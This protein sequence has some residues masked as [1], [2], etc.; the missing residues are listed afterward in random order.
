MEMNSNIAKE[1]FNL[2]PFNNRFLAR[3]FSAGKND[4]WIYLIGIVATFLGYS[5][6]QLLTFKPLVDFALQNGVTI[7]QSN[8]NSI[9]NADEIGMNRSVMLCILGGMFVFALLFLL[10]VVKYLH[11]KPIISII[12]AFEK[13]R[14]NRYFF[15]FLIW[16]ILNGLYILTMYL[17]NPS[18][19]E[20]RF[21][22]NSFLILL[23][24][25]IVFL[26]I[27][28]AAEE[29]FL[30]SYLMQGL[31]IVF[32]NGIM[33]L[34]ITSV[35][36][37][38]MHSSNPETQAYGFLKM[39]PFYMCFGAFLGILTLLDE[40]AEIA[41][42]IHC[43]NNLISSLLVCSKNSV[44][45]TDSILFIK[46]ENPMIEFLSWSIM[47]IIC[48]FILSKKYSLSNWKLIIR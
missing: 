30:R 46:T 44:L 36:F 27:Q 43:A 37:G 26:P 31:S 24:T 39:M 15:G 38:L 21:E 17:I 18:N 45:K 12:T 41:M 3:G 42:G 10:A 48:F 1:E 29:L 8:I 28:T 14:W 5:L 40:G 25:V 32:K 11:K 35:L 20:L 23:I 47:A 33:S 9:Y 22:P 34:I 16:G 13:V 7:N 4:V 2:S 19:Y 6:F